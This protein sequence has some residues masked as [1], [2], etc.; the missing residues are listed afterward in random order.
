LRYVPDWIEF[1]RA[2][3]MT[4]E[5]Q[6]REGDVPNVAED[7]FFAVRDGKIS[8]RWDTAPLDEFIPL[9]EWLHPKKDGAPAR[10]QEVL[11]RSADLETWLRT[12]ETEAG[13]TDATTKQITPKRGKLSSWIAE[14]YPQGIPAGTTAK[15]IA[16]EFQRATDISVGERTVRRALGRK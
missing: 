5:R 15:G 2:V 6:G 13:S 1:R 9:S 8:T 4:A 11:V 10:I 7:L 16:R 14:Q 12:L 3:E